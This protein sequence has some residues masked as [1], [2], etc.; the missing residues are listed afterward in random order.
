ML[1]KVVSVTMVWVLH[2]EGGV[3][4]NGIGCAAQHGGW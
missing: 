4:W 3:A 1:A 2:G